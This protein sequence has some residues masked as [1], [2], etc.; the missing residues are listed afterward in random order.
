M[1]FLGQIVQTFGFALA[2]VIMVF[3][4]A[5]VADVVR[6]YEPIEVVIEPS[7]IITPGHDY[8]ATDDSDDWDESANALGI[9]PKDMTIEQFID[10]H[11]TP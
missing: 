4:L 8:D 3:T 7:F 10:H 11:H 9:D 1:K 2:M 6:P 5:V